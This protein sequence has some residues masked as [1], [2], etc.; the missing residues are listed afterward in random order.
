MIVKHLLSYLTYSKYTQVYKGLRGEFSCP[1]VK[2]VIIKWF[3]KSVGY[4]LLKLDIH[5][6]CDIAYPLYLIR[7]VL[8]ALFVI[9]KNYK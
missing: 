2:S 7:V 9:G 4:Y 8:E 6:P 1:E 5:I 3:L